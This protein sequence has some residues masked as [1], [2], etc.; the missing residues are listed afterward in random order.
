MGESRS[1]VVDLEK[2]TFDLEQGAAVERDYK[3]EA[4][5]RTGM[6]LGGFLLLL[7]VIILVSS[8][9]WAGFAAAILFAAVI[10]FVVSI[11]RR[12]GPWPDEDDDDVRREVV[13]IKAAPAPPAEIE[14]R[15]FDLLRDAPHTFILPTLLPLIL[16]S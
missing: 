12:A 13:D 15:S 14:S 8:G 3:E 6:F 5:R 1:A 4:A 7:D 16:Y 2:A 11:V 10:L 9:L